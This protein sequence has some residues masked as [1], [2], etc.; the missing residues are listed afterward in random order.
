V[1]GVCGVWTGPRQP[2]DCVCVCVRGMS[3]NVCVQ[4]MKTANQICTVI[5]LY[6]PDRSSGVPP[7]S[8]QCCRGVSVVMRLMLCPVTSSSLGV[9][10][11][12]FVSQMTPDS[13]YCAL[14]LTSVYK[15]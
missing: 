8:S 6:F 10:L 11:S 7:P 14:L 2:Q 12:L 5:N 1:G 15:E 4:R 3:L 13:L 9:L